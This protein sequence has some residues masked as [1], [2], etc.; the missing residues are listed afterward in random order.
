M[1]STGRGT[2][3]QGDAARAN[4]QVP[5][6]IFEF[7]SPGSPVTRAVEEFTDATSNA[8]IF[9]T[10][11][12]V[13]VEDSHK[14]AALKHLS[15][16]K[17]CSLLSDTSVSATKRIALLDM[18]DYGG[19]IKILLTP[20]AVPEAMLA[21]VHRRTRAILQASTMRR[22]GSATNLAFRTKE[23]FAQANPGERDTCFFKPVQPRTLEAMCQTF[24]VIQFARLSQYTSFKTVT[25]E[26][27]EAELRLTEPVGIITLAKHAPGEGGHFN[28]YIRAGTSWYNADNSYAVLRERTN[29]QPTWKTVTALGPKAIVAFMIYC[30]A[31]TS[32]IP[33]VTPPPA[34]G[35]L[36]GHPTFAQDGMGSCSVDA[37]SSVLCFADGFRDIM[38]TAMSAGINEIV[39]RHMA[40]PASMNNTVRYSPSEPRILDVPRCLETVEGFITTSGLSLPPSGELSTGNSMP[41]KDFIRRI[42]RYLAGTAIRFHSIRIEAGLGH[43]PAMKNVSWGIQSRRVPGLKSLATSRR[44]KSTIRRRASPAAASARPGMAVKAIRRRSESPVNRMSAA[45]RQRNRTRRNRQ[46][47]KI[48]AKRGRH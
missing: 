23:L 3:I 10:M 31:E 20:D 39:E 28:A 19:F 12:D 2:I 48:N 9:Y 47:K 36:H 1:S 21:E 45:A 42:I 14:R 46:Q 37:L 35:S 7:G 15:A 33:Q 22:R 27:E 44:M 17:L 34:P 11:D 8:E 13:S 30:Y 32:K 40:V 6:Y 43:V 4:G 41:S 5:P 16:P 25:S 24:P 29:G 26:G 38:A 18:L